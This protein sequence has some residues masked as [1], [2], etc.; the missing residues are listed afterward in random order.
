MSIRCV[1]MGRRALVC[2]FWGLSISVSAL[3]QE[4]AANSTEVAA[5]KEEEAAAEPEGIYFHYALFSRR[6]QTERSW[7]GR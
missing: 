6:P 2:F 5:T 4:Q 1:V 3:A 7:I